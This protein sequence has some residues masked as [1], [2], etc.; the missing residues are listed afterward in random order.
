MGETAFTF[1]ESAL[2]GVGSGPVYYRGFMEGIY[3]KLATYDLKSAK[4]RG[5]DNQN[6]VIDLTSHSGSTCI[7]R[8]DY[9][10]EKFT[11]S[12]YRHR[13]DEGKTSEQDVLWADRQQVVSVIDTWLRANNILPRTANVPGLR[14]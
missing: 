1:R 13:S 7:I 12:T 9:G 8:L 4:L 14:S 3:S 11:I 2:G 5:Q 6:D 10:S